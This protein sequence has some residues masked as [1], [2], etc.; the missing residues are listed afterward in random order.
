MEEPRPSSGAAEATTE[1]IRYTKWSGAGNTFLLVTREGLPP[2]V[3]GAALA[4]ALC[5]GAGAPG[6]DG[7]LL[8]RDREAQFWNRDGS[9]AAFCGNSA[10]CLAAHVLAHSG[11]A[12]VQIRVGRV[13]VQG[14]RV[15]E[16]IAIRVPAPRYLARSLSAGEFLAELGPLASRVE[17]MAWIEAG[18]PHLC[19]RLAGESAPGAT[20]AGE[21]A[22]RRGDSGRADFS[23]LARAG[24][25]LRRHARFGPEGTNVDFLWPA[26]AKGPASIPAAPLPGAWPAGGTVG[27]QE[28][29][30]EGPVPGP[31]LPLEG[32]LETFERGLEDL[33]PACGSG[34][35]A[36]A[37]L[38]LEGHGAGWV[39]LHLASGASLAVEKKGPAWTMLGPACPVAR[40]T[41]LWTRATAGE[42]PSPPPG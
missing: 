4:R 37:F 23:A 20:G 34:V 7:L 28:P 26:T 6:A 9:P 29:A 35:L 1:R 12:R 11:S 22:G 36:A 38:L 10:R 32:R 33:S 30:G 5:G 8:V 18:V 14:W 2:E 40:G 21:G 17:E 13:D 31:P 16:E 42:S 15:G 41:F 39:R 24:A 19:L 27:P 25:A 3:E